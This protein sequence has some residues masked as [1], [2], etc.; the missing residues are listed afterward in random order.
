MHYSTVSIATTYCRI[1]CWSERISQTTKLALN[2]VS[3]LKNVV[4]TLTGVLNSSKP[5]LL[6]STE[7]PSE[8]SPF[9]K[10]SS[11]YSPHSTDAPLNKGPFAPLNAVTKQLKQDLHSYKLR[12]DLIKVLHQTS[13]VFFS[14]HSSQL[15]KSRLVFLS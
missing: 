1:L 6:F 10:F 3:T 2:T 7:F 8:T 11:D 12:V 13:L 15:T 5:S 9:N 4:L 14:K